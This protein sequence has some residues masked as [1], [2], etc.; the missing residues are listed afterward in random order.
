MENAYR[1]SEWYWIERHGQ[2]RIGQFE[3]INV[4]QAISWTFVPPPSVELTLRELSPGTAAVT[5]GPFIYLVD[6]EGQRSLLR[7]SV[8]LMLEVF[9]LCQVYGGRDW[10]ALKGPPSVS[11]E[12][13]CLQEN[14]HGRSLDY[15]L[16]K[17]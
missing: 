14:I 15:T 1:T 3:I 11:I 10:E 16:L 5:A 12:W 7:H 2:D 13:C 9:G 4:L 8:N 6:N 17:C